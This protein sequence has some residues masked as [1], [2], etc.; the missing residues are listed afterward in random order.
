M[1]NN[2]KIKFLI[3]IKLFFF[4]SIL[5]LINE[6]QII[7]NNNIVNESIYQKNLDF[8]N[9]TS[10]YKI[11]AIYYSDNNNSI[12]NNETAQN[13]N[14]NKID[15]QIKLAKNHGLYGFGIMHHLSNISHINENL[16]NIISEVNKLNFRF[17][18]IINYNENINYNQIL[19]IKNFYI[20]R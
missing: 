6:N 9:L 7:K 16:F 1:R 13:I 14:N 8:S 4:S 18:I 11:I 5:S 20:F 15:K 19:L 2:L 17:F 3:F 10:K 12:I